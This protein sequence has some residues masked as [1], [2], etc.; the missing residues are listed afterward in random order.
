MKQGHIRNLCKT[1]LFFLLRYALNRPDTNN[2]WCFDRCREF[3]FEPNGCLDLWAREHF[4]SSVITFAA[5]IQDILNDPEITVGI[6]SHTRPI[7]KGFLRQIKREFE[8]NVMLKET[9]PDVLYANPQKES[10]KW[11]E[12][13][14][15]VVRRKGN[16]KEATIE[17]WGLVD[18]MPTSKHYQLRVYDDVVTRESVTTPEQIH[19][20]TEA[21]DLSDNLG[22]VG[23]SIRMIGTRYALGD[24]YEEMI[25]RGAVKPRI[26]AATDNG[27]VDGKPVYF[28]QEEWDRRLQFQSPAIIASQMLQNPMAAGTVI[29]QA[30]WFHLWPADKA[31]PRFEAVFQSF[32]GAYSEK[33]TSD[34]RCLMTFGLFKHEK[35]KDSNKFCAMVLDCVMEQKSYPDMRDIVI[36]DYQNKF[37][38]NEKKVD[39]IIIEDASSG[40]ALIPD[41][42]KAHI[43]VYPY[44]PGSLDKT[45]RASLVSH[46][47]R[48]GYL[49]IP[50][51]RSP[52]RRG[53]PMDWLS[54]WHEQ[55]L[56]F[57]NVKN[58]DGV[59]A[60]TMFL[61]VMDKMG[62]LRGQQVPQETLSYWRKK[63]AQGT[64]G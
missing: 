51:S 40:S 21:M 54:R 59:D 23:G 4:K 27:R 50:E 43:T 22:K 20:T 63:M 47:V 39:A 31:L 9:F 29:F 49:F 38:A 46:F 26:Y 36:K 11:S 57:P 12:D 17:A 8:N 30:D 10:P 48:D 41:L 14:G 32:D 18:G 33:A 3:Q 56:Y 61:S 28:S 60:T 45:A 35:D 7:A 2:Q 24:T 15:I 44:K 58:D 64:Y 16:P 37:G 1:D 52:K 13:E 42:R 25:K 53:Y 6:F 34:Y 62:F 55:M 5:T 19:K